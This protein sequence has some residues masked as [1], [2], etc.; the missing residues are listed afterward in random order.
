[1]IALCDAMMM[2]PPQTS[3]SP[4]QKRGPITTAANG[5]KYARAFSSESLPRIG[6]G[7]GTGLREENAS[8]QE[9]RAPVPIQSERKRL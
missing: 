3:L 7:V 2:M 6:C 1:M 4:P 8:K 9:T 5:F